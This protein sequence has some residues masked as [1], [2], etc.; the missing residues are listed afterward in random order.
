MKIRHNT[1]LVVLLPLLLLI[2]TSALCAQE[3]IIIDEE[4]SEAFIIIDEEPSEVAPQKIIIKG[5][6]KAPDPRSIPGQMSIISAEEIAASAPKNL[7]DVLE[8]VL[9]VSLTRYGGAGASSFIS[10][11]GS[12][13]EQVLILLNGKRLNT[14]Q[15]GGSDLSTINPDSIERIEV[16]RG[17][18]SAIYGENA[19]GGVVNIIT[20]TSDSTDLHGTARAGYGSQNTISG[21]AS[22]SG[23]TENKNLGGTF[24][25]HA[26]SSDG[27]YSFEDDNFGSLERK[28]ADVL[29]GGAAAAAFYSPTD[30]LN[31]AFDTTIYFDEKGVPGTVEFPSETARMSDERETAMLEGDWLHDWGDITGTLSFFRQVR[32]YEDPDFYLGP[33]DDRHENKVA[34]AEVEYEKRFSA[35]NWAASWLSGYSLRLDT[36]D[37]TAFV[38]SGGSEFSD[39]GITRLR[40]SGFT[41]GELRLFPYRDSETCRLSIFPALRLDSWSIDGYENSSSTAGTQATWKLGLLSPLD[42]RKHYVLKAS[43]GTSYRAPSFDDLFWPATSFA[44][45]NPELNPEESWYADGGVILQPVPFIKLEAA[46]FYRQVTNLIQWNPG[47]GGRWRP[48]NIGSSRFWGIESEARSLID[49]PALDSYMELTANGSY[50]HAEDRT[51]DSATYGKILPRKP[52][53]SFS[54]VGTLTNSAGHSLRIEGR[55]IGLRYIT[56]ANTKWYDPCFITDATAT[57]ALRNDI[58]LVVSGNNLFNISYVDIREYPVPGIELSMEL[59]YAF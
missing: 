1:L 2:R 45:G 55:Y 21:G 28:N 58:D 24:S 4:G 26:L 12:S 47:P 7:A 37:S 39:S 42:S 13:A 27:N 15:G 59:R 16:Y 23:G 6:L 56:A 30:T 20:K 3:T 38:E 34:E 25:L 29:Q 5:K 57:V 9:G 53:W 32:Q 48:I 43:G 46:A 8:P 31:L 19:V 40:Q 50:L 41:R 18:E 51:E 44:T 33:V 49:L 11:R 54:G 10:I 36:L 14:A 35:E 52:V 17:G 22:I